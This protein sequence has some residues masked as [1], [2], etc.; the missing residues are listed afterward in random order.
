[1]ITCYFVFW[2]SKGVRE[3]EILGG[4]YFT[5]GEIEDVE[6][7]LAGSSFIS[8]F[9]VGDFAFFGGVGGSFG[10]VETFVFIFIAWI[11]LVRF[12]DVFVSCGSRVCFI[13]LEY[14]N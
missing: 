11:R 7:L 1:M 6:I 3:V 13:I 5:D 14:S 9:R 10:G 12:V 4:V 8:S 2:S